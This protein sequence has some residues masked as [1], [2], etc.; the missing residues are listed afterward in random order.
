MA[1]NRYS[2][3]PLPGIGDGVAGYRGPAVANIVGVSYRQLDH[4]T[5]TGLV[6]A[7][8]RDAQGSGTQRLYSFDDIVA[9]RVIKRLRD[10]GVSLQRIR[11]AMTELEDRGLDLRHITLVSDSTNTVYAVDDR[12]EVAD[13]LFS[14]QGVFAIA[15]EPLVEELESQVVAITPERAFPAVSD[16][17]HRSAS[18]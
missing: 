7:S 16:T 1:S 11:R 9:L 15:I 13:L 4:W 8:V 12:N 5:T 18:G 14:G 6:R 2:D 3:I 10:A 17:G